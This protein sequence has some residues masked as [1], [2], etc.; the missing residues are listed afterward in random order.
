VCAEIQA[1]LTPLAL[2]C[3]CVVPSTR[4]ALVRSCRS[5]VAAYRGTRFNNQAADDLDHEGMLTAAEISTSNYGLHGAL[6]L[7]AVAL[8]VGMN[9]CPS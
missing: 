9:N 7:S 6:I 2:E 4:G 3:S 8:R 1:T 5:Y